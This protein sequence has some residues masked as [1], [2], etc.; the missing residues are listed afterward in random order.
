MPRK[1]E[2]ALLF[3]AVLSVTIVGCQ[4]TGEPVAVADLERA[5][6]ALAPFRTQLVDALTGALEEGGAENAIRVCRERAPE[7]AAALSI[8]GVQMGR[9]S[10]KVRNPAN[11]PAPWVEPLLE[12]YL[13]SPTT[14][15]P[16]AVYIDEATMGYVEP[17]YVVHFCLSCHGPSIDSELLEEIQALYPEDQATGF[18]AND[19]RGVFWVT[20]P[21]T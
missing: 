19:L 8:D 13:E 11:A 12:E 14:A 10:H 7:I 4:A 1:L 9:T 15:R 2:V 6:E 18:K 17:I 5:Q 3:A 20:M 21:R 16:R